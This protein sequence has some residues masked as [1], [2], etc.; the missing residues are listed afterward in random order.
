[1]IMTKWDGTEVKEGRLE[2]RS[3]TRVRCVAHGNLL[4][5][6]Q[7]PNRWV[8]PRPEVIVTLH[9]MPSATEKCTAV[10]LG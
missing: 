5:C 9:N 4:L 10:C 7:S 1:V 6:H 2:G 8:V 3:G